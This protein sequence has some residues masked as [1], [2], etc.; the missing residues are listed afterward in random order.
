MLVGFYFHKGDGSTQYSPPFP[1][2]GLAATF[3]VQVLQLVGSPSLTV[4]VEHK[5]IEDTAFALAGT[6]VAITTVSVNELDVSS[7]KEIIRLGYT[8]AATNAWEGVL[9]NVLAPAW[10]PY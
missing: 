9:M 8:I 10:R 6:F 5:N 4:R 3:V 2:G 7:L 1:R